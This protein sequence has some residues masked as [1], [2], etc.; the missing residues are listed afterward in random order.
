MSKAI[1]E[2]QPRD[3]VIVGDSL[4]AEIAQEYFEHDSPYRVVAFAVEE[5]YRSQERLHGLPVLT[6]EKLERS[7]DPAQHSVFV[8]ITYGKLNRTR[9]RLLEESKRKGFLPASYISSRAFVWR[10]VQLGEH[11]FVFEDNTLQPFV[12]IGRNCILWS[13]NH[14]GHHSVIGE[15]SFISSHV[16][17]SG[18]VRVGSNCFLGVN[19]TVVNDVEIGEDTW[20]GPGVLVTRDLESNSIWRAPRSERR[21]TGAR[22]YFKV[23]D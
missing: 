17:I 9:T 4:F 12:T 23:S 3:L 13:G 10:N 21:T 6:F 11:C 15:N 19:A 7:L 20:I 22:E 18:S 2:V 8:A 14:I 5:R 16:V 1:D